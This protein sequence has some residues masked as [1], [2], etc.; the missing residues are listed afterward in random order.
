MDLSKND[1]LTRQNLYSI[2]INNSNL[3]RVKKTEMNSNTLYNLSLT[4]KDEMS[5]AFANK[6]KGLSYIY[7]SENEKSVELFYKSKKTFIKFNAIERLIALNKDIAQV[8][9]FSCDFLGSNKTLFE[10]LQLIKK[11]D[12]NLYADL[13]RNYKAIA[14]NFFSLKDYN[15]SI[16]F[17]KKALKYSNNKLWLINSSFLG[18]AECYYKLG[19]YN[20]ALFYFDKILNNRKSISVNPGNFYS[21]KATTEHIKLI[22]NKTNTSPG[23]FYEVE[24][25]YSKN[26]SIGG[27]V[28]N[29]IYL[30]DYFIMNK[31]TSKAINAA[32]KAFKISKNDRNPLEII[33]SLQQL[34][35]VDQKNASK[36]AQ[37]YIRINDSMQIAERRFRNKYAQIVYETNEILEQKNK[38]IKQNWIIGTTAGVIIL[39]I[40]LLLIITKQRAKQKDMQFQQSQQKANEEIY[41]LMLT[42]KSKEDQARQSEKKRIAAEL[43]DGVMNKLASTRLNLNVLSNKKDKA[44][45]DKCLI[46][47]DEIHKIEQEIRNI[48]HDLNLDIFNAA[49]SF[50]IFL[51]DFIATQNETMTSNYTLEID[52]TIDWGNISSGIKMNLFRIIQEASHNVNKYAQA[53]HVIISLILD[54]NNICL[55]IT[56]DG[57]G[58]DTNATSEGI[59][60]KNIKKRV[61][62]LK[63]KFI[64]QSDSKSTSINIAIP[65]PVL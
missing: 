34:I 2:G 63:G 52:S 31:D 17:E 32:R 40:A 16:L 64:I 41:D 23:V 21:A 4:S 12:K 50:V 47:I 60:L 55:S 13:W 61:E 22:I 8:Q 11:S 53:T 45:I 5:L 65:L 20:K 6:L 39:V 36:N 9:Y 26:L 30:S 38:A 37:E 62:Y 58:F 46:H 59:G 44:T 28:I 15:N 27:R 19:N 29:Q 3:F 24:D 1:S 14:N 49:N 57:K 56:D 54:E 48:A 51:N 7:K 33:C 35:K 10:N 25:F 43:H 42:Q 18:I